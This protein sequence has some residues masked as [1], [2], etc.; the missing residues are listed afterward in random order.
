MQNL[1]VDLGGYTLMVSECP[2]PKTR[3]VD[4]RVE[5]VVDRA[6]NA[7]LFTVSLFA[8]LRANE[9]GRRGKGEEIKVTVETDP[10]EGF[11]EGT[12]VQLVNA[13]VSPYSFQNERT[14]QMLS[15][16]SFKATGL[17]PVQA[18][19]KAA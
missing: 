17:T 13:R 8:K 3:E 9:S 5:A 1:P 11:E 19:K 14:G 15:G 2:E 6:T 18:S 10:G 4:G 12:Y 16:L 7:R